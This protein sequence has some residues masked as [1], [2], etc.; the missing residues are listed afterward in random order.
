MS[1]SKTI[2]VV[3]DQAD[4]RLI[5]EDLLTPEFCVKSASDGQQA[6][7]MLQQDP[8]RIDLILMDIQMPVMDGL[9]AC[10]IIKATM[11]LMDIPLLFITSSESD[12]DEA[13]ALSLG[14]E[15]L[16]HKPY[17]EAVVLARVNNNLQLAEARRREHEYAEKLEQE[18][19]QRTEEVV[20]KSNE[21]V[22]QNNRLLASQ[23][24]TIT[25]FCT[26]AEVR[27]NETGNHILRTQNYV[28]ALAQRLQNHPRFRDE[29]TDHNIDLL[30][31]SA[32]LHDIGKVAIPD[33]ILLKPGKLDAEEWKIMQRHSEYGAKAIARAEH[34]L[35]EGGG[36]SFL[37]YAREIAL[38]HHERWD[39]GGYPQGLKGDDIPLSARLMAVADV[40]DALISKRVYKD[41]FSHEKAVGIIREEAGSHF[42]PDIVQ[43]MLDIEQE[44]RQIAIRFNDVEPDRERSNGKP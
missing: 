25:A 19:E 20:A 40:Y 12:A 42:D 7:D 23:Q 29:L 8:S 32:P 13:Y 37:R 3:D 4:S 15:D 9:E 2:L 39:G 11:N 30:Y 38:S 31:R 28:L 16:I 44:F 36:G 17:S 6:L 18:V 41:S 33:R 22:R 14:A 10:K 24:A 21:L 43:P 5:L 1:Q 35:S 34:D 26:L 27:D